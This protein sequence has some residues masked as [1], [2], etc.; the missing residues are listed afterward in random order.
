MQRDREHVVAQGMAGGPA[1]DPGGGIGPARTLALAA[2]VALSPGA[3]GGAGGGPARDPA[4][5]GLGR[6]GFLGSLAGLGAILCGPARARAFGG[7]DRVEIGQ[8]VYGAGG[9]G[10]SG[11]Q[12]NPVPRPDALRRLLW[13]VEKR[14][15]IEVVPEAAPVRLTDAGELHRRPLLYLAGDRAFPLPP[16]EDL[17]R[18]RR[19][20]GMG[21]MLI[22]DSAEGRAGGGF[23][24]SVRALC[25]RVLP[26]HPLARLPEDHVLY[27]S[28]YLLRLPVG[29]VLALPY[30]E[31]VLL[32]GGPGRAG[33][34]AVVYSQND[35][36]GAWARDRFG[37]WG[38]DVVPGG[39]LQ[40]EQ[41]L[42]LGVNLAMY[43]LCLDY[44]ADQAHVPFIMRRRA[45]QAPPPTTQTPDKPE[46][47]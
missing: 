3:R 23:D 22:I 20:L 40:R 30:L 18:L 10:G 36:G 28:F 12:G 6:R 7:R 9:A 27:R 34:A 32:G 35:L 25:A 43:A 16:D 44:K 38:Y 2:P 4:H 39:E 17:A 45:W 46:A 13:E 37:Q 14:T 11:S 26:G 47:P 31:A 29:R 24:Q 33:R 21:G 5:T 19:H 15:S 1:Q 42:R 8:I 41:A